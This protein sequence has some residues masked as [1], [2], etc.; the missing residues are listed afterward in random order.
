MTI[1]PFEKMCTDQG[2]VIAAT[3]ERPP[4]HMTLT[5]NGNA[6]KMN[7]RKADADW[8]RASWAWR[9]T[10]TFNER[11]LE[12]PFYCGSAH[13]RTFT[14]AD[15]TYYRPTAPSAADVLACLI[16]DA[17][18]ADQ[19]FEDWCEELGEDPDSR[20]ALATYLSCQES[21]SKVKH[22][23]G[24]RYAEFRGMSGEH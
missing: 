11:T 24:A 4:T 5:R 19:Y 2:V 9:V 15:T 17:E 22:L 12:V 20:K 10:L 7:E 21:G 1:T 23:L 18:L 13:C 8:Q 6:Y 16:S 14:F 3:L